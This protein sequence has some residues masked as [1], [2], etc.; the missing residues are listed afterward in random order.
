MACVASVL[1]SC[2]DRSSGLVSELRLVIL[3]VPGR[4]SPPSLNLSFL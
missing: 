4:L 2:K 3:H 1:E